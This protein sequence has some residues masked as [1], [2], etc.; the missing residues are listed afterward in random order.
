MLLSALYVRLRDVDEIWVVV[1]Q[2]LFFGSPI[3]YVV[4]MYPESVR[5]A[6]LFNPLAAAFTQVR[7]AV[8]DPHA[9][10]AAEAIGGGMLLL[11][12][13][14]IVLLVFGSG[15]AVFQR[16]SGHAAERL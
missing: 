10:T 1:R 4:A 16:L 12:P 9:P 14:G 7:F 13:V 6:A 8:L 2:A 11:V 15:L 5:E 3:F